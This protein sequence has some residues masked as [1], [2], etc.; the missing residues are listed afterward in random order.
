MKDA[1]NNT[2]TIC[3]C[4]SCGDSEN[5]SSWIIQKDPK[6]GSLNI[7]AFGNLQPL[8]NIQPSLMIYEDC[9]SLYIARF[10]D[11]K[12]LNFSMD[13]LKPSVSMCQPTAERHSDRT[14]ACGWNLK[15]LNS[16]NVPKLGM[17]MSV[18]TTAAQKE[19]LNS[20]GFLVSLCIYIYISLAFSLHIFEPYNEQK[21]DT[22]VLD[23]DK[24]FSP[25]PGLSLRNVMVS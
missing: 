8:A 14:Y 1:E 25:N 16:S 7:N 10:L 20:N 2:Q 9:I 12:G 4:H 22:M 21:L 24:P 17:E 5:L 15:L 13:H 11:G 3:L 23:D 6:G 18:S 19:R